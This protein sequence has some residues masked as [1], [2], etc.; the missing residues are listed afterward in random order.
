MPECDNALVS[1][2]DG[3]NKNLR[4]SATDLRVMPSDYSS[5]SP[6]GT[7]RLSLRR[8]RV[9]NFGKTPP[10]VSKIIDSRNVD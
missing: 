3:A 2:R 10:T 1:P 6:G 9:G 7:V 8:L 4:H 5:S